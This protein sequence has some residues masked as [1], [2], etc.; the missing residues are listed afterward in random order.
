MMM[1]VLALGSL[2]S[3]VCT[4]MTGSVLGMD[5]PVSN[6]DA[7]AVSLPEVQYAEVNGASLGYREYGAGEPLLLICG[8]GATMDN[9]N[10][11]FIDLLASHYHVYTFDHRGMGFSTDNNATPSIQQFADDVHVLMDV[12]GHESMNTYG[13]SMGSS[14][15]QQLVISYP[16]CVRKMVLSS[17]T[18]SVRIPEAAMLLGILESIVD[19]PS[20]PMGMRNEA[21]ANLDWNGSWDGLS[22]I[23]KPIMLIVGTD[24]V[25]T[26]DPISVQIAGQINGS[27][28][29]RFE[30]VPHSGQTFV[31]VQYAESI[32]N[33]LDMNESPYDEVAPDAPTDL[34]L[35]EG[36]DDVT[37]SWTPPSYD[38]QSPITGYKIYR[39]DS[40]AGPYE[41]LTAVNGTSYVDDDIE[42]GCAYWY[43]VSAVNSVGEGAF[44]D[45]IDI[46]VDV[47]DDDTP[48]YLVSAALVIALIAIIVLLVIR[49]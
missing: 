3:I 16:E 10:S 30:G 5:D 12:L 27:W 31:P 22:S 2:F 32:I 33:F 41:L 49:R 35:Q 36:G 20:Q 26:P 42:E 11:T 1:A 19:D 7:S 37:I 48:F 40:A 44:S 15:S 14:I 23:D 38:G 45:A 29:V 28:L 47:A 24:D 25:L 17:A 46:T 8:F 4:P 6:V 18:Y 9:W 39:S 43:K 21:R 34:G 13:T